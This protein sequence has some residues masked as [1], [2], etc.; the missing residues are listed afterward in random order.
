M[1]GSGLVSKVP[2]NPKIMSHHELNQGRFVAE[3]DLHYVVEPAAYLELKDP[4]FS[5]PICSQ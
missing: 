2:P 3:L 4:R 5:T 1:R